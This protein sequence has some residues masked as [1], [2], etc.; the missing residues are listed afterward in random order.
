MSKQERI[1]RYMKEQQEKELVNP[2][3]EVAKLIK[4]YQMAHYEY[5]SAKLTLQEA[6][7]HIKK[8]ISQAEYDRL[9]GENSGYNDVDKWIM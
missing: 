4:K 5:L 8:D 6:L 2:S 1:Q 7:I 9:N 3:T